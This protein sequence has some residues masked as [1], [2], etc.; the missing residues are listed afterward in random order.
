MRDVPLHVTGEKI[1]KANY[2]KWIRMRDYIISCELW[3]R[4]PMQKISVA[5]ML[6]PVRLHTVREEAVAGAEAK[7]KVGAKTGAKMGAKMG[8]KSG[9]EADTAAGETLDAGASSEVLQLHVPRSRSHS[10]SISK[11]NSVISGSSYSSVGRIIGVNSARRPSDNLMLQISAH[12]DGDSDD[13]AGGDTPSKAADT[14]ANAVPKPVRPTSD[15][16]IRSNDTAL[17]SANPTDSSNGSASDSD[18]DE[19][20]DTSMV[21]GKSATTMMSPSLAL[22]IGSGMTRSDVITPNKYSNLDSGSLG[23]AETPKARYIFSNVNRNRS[24]SS[25]KSSENSSPLRFVDGPNQRRTLPGASNT[26]LHSNST[27]AILPTSRAMTPSHRYRLRKEMRDVALKKSIKQKEKF[28]EEQDSNLDLKDDNVDASLIWNIPMASYS[29][30]SFLNTTDSKHKDTNIK[31]TSPENNRVVNNKIERQDRRFPQK[32]QV[33]SRSQPN[34]PRLQQR[35]MKRPVHQQQQPITC[36]EDIPATPIPGVSNVT[37]TEFIQDTIQN[38]SSVYLHSQEMKSRG[39]LEKRQSSTQYLPLN[40]KE[41]SDLGMEDLVLVSDKKLEAVSS[42]RPTYLPPKSTKEK[43]MHEHEISKYMKMASD[44]QI[45]RK[46]SQTKHMEEDKA[47]HERYAHLLQRG[48]TRKSSLF[49]L[50]KISWKTAISDELRCSIYHTILESDA[51]LVSSKYLENFDYLNS[52]LDQMDFP[53]DKES[54]IKQ[55][56]EKNITTKIGYSS[57]K[58]KELTLLLKL[59]SISKQGLLVGDA[60]LFHNFLNCKSFKTLKDI[61]EIANLIQLTCFNDTCKDKFDSRIIDPRGITARILHSPSFK[62]EMTS[63]IMNFNTWWNIMSRIDNNLFMWI[64]DIIVIEN[65]QCFTNKQINKDQ[66]RDKN[67]D[68]YV[69]KYV[70][71][72]Y[73]ILASLAASVLLDYHFG[74]NDLKHLERIDKKFCIPLYSEDTEC[75]I[76]NSSFIKKWHHQYKKY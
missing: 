23:I 47:N 5:S 11:S 16:S 71:V 45:Q 68:Y 27:S 49:D 6:K 2:K 60:Q 54:E 61:W 70:V 9:L 12:S 41:M 65:C 73:K 50:R 21:S 53:T 20:H 36:F 48:I 74:F 18:Y 63:S 59:K 58:D 17:F 55:I 33:H 1:N 30:S 46:I 42:S 28:Y 29:T 3:T 52:I 13:E 64:M 7:A 37:D 40:V 44:E 66:L 4:D 32:N 25:I 26:Y 14:H 76:I 34:L 39:Q 75:N 62:A 31:V 56:I 43:Q 8:A 72:N 67:W 15:N 38:L 19:Q 69:N 57:V 22:S 24:Q 10:Q 51:Q 35:P